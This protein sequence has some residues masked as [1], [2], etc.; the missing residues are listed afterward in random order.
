MINAN[1]SRKQKRVAQDFVNKFLTALLTISMVLQSSPVSYAYAL[2][3]GAEP[4]V[5]VVEAASEEEAVVETAPEQEVASAVEEPAPAPEVE[6]ALAKEVAIAPAE[7]EATPDPEATSEPAAEPEQATEEPVYEE[8]AA[9]QTEEPA[10]QPADE[11]PAN[12]PV[13]G[14]DQADVLPEDEPAEPAEQDEPEAVATI[15]VSLDHARLIYGSATVSEGTI[16]VPEGQDAN[17]TIAVDE[18][19]EL[20]EVTVEANGDTYVVNPAADGA[21]TL[22]GYWAQN[23]TRIVASTKAIPSKTEYIYM[24]TMTSR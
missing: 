12:Q 18:G 10:E 11:E 24:R 8:P 14:D 17:V 7:S 4:E 21:Y 5:Q 19:Y 16:E 2:E 22:P 23:G 6:P 13:V 15:A 20:D 1:L 9:E 3:E